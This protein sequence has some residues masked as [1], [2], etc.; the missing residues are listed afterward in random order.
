MIMAQVVYNIAESVFLDSIQTFLTTKDVFTG[1]IKGIVFGALIAIIG[2]NWGLTTT[3]GA[4]GVGQSTT[5]AVV[6]SLLAIF[7]AD[8]LLSW[9]MFQ[10][11]GGG[12][13]LLS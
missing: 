12:G 8:F 5:A 2:C 6:T 4:K 13:N 11:A 9:I 10:G 7:I 3:G 1:P